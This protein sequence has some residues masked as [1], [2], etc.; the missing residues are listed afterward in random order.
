MAEGGRV[1]VT[2]WEQHM[3]NNVVL[4]SGHRRRRWPDIKTTLVRR[5]Q[6]LDGEVARQP[7][8]G[9]EITLSN[10][11]TLIVPTNWFIEP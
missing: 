4:M 6:H 7:G 1:L 9:S 5:L 2:S 8:Q 3:K 11:A 10:W